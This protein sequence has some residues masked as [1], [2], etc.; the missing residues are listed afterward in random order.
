MGK[1]VS[2]QD[3][4]MRINIIISDGTGTAE[5]SH[6]LSGNEGDWVSCKRSCSSTL[7]L[8]VNRS[9]GAID[10]RLEHLHRRASS[11]GCA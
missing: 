6:W 4:N 2:V 9:K 3:S 10:R 11:M 5:V 7:L 1:I 8:V